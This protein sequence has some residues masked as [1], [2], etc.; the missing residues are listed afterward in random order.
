MQMNEQQIQALTTRLAAILLQR[1][2][3]LCTVESC[4]GGGIAKVCTDI[5]GSSEWF[6]GALVTY[7][8][9]AK[10]SILG[11]DSSVLKQ[12]GAVSKQVVSAMTQGALACLLKA[13]MA[14][15]VSGIAGPAGGTEDK[16]VGMV[17]CA[18]QLR[19]QAAQTQCF[20]FVGNRGDVRCAAVQAA[21]EGIIKRVIS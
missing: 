13:D 6:E 14:V 7:S 5:A 4:T 21:I 10:Q 18:W 11:I 12:H 1:R 20:Q 15:A 16:R 19:H 3:R 2:L 17:W 9:E 8:N